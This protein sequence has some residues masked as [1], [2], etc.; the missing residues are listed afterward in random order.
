MD[1][2]NGDQQEMDMIVAEESTATEVSC[3]FVYGSI[4]VPLG[5]AKKEDDSASHQWCIYIRSPNRNGAYASN[6]LSL[7]IDKV[8]FSL[9]PSFPKPTRV[10]TSAP[11]E[12]VEFGWG[13]FEINIQ[14]FFKDPAVSSIKLHPHMLQLHPFDYDPTAMPRII[15]TD[16]I[17]SEQY[18]EVLI[19]SPPPAFLD[20]LMQ[21]Q[22]AYDAYQLNNP[23]G[24]SDSSSG[25][26]SN[27][28]T[29]KGAHGAAVSFASKYTDLLIPFGEAQTLHNERA[30]TQRY[31][32]IDEKILRQIQTLS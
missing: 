11:F 5:K 9:H 26:S 28:N 6:D 14:I 2:L 7:F 30:W 25:T 21:Y 15:H 20:L 13:E 23:D 31:R 8:V 1:D 3:P 18:E 29:T 32:E 22:P 10:V 4:A 19:N 27:A 17:V 16:P 12:V 24:T